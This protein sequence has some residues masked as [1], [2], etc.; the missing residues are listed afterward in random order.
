MHGRVIGERG[1]TR[2]N[3]LEVPIKYTIKGPRANIQTVVAYVNA[4][5]N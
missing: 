4:S 5:N 3:G 1:N 2:Q